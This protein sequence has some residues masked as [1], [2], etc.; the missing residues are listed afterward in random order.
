M[1]AHEVCRWLPG[2]CVFVTAVRSVVERYYDAFNARDWDAWAALLDEDVE[3]TIEGDT[4]VGPEAAYAYTAETIRHYPGMRYA[5][6][7]VVAESNDMIVMECRLVNPAGER[8]A[9][10]WTLD[11]TGMP[12]LPG[13]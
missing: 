5:A 11:G 12:D 7:R 4:L 8:S 6:E 9:D 2:S 10:A 3:I 13:Q 1:L